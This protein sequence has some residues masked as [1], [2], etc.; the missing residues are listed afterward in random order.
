MLHPSC[1]NS[2]EMRISGLVSYLLLWH[3]VWMGLAMMHERLI[4][5][6]NLI[7]AMVSDEG[8]T[9]FELTKARV[10]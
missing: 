5:R 4:M 1:C 10:D 3:K 9:P 2:Y 8:K 7:L 6:A